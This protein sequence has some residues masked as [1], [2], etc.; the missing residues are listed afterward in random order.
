MKF[1][2]KIITQKIRSQNMFFFSP[3]KVYFA[4]KHCLKLKQFNLIV[5]FTKVKKNSKFLFSNSKTVTNHQ[6]IP[7][8]TNSFNYFQAL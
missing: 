7:I 3:F 5:K 8:K 1:T 4:Q 6:A 2:K